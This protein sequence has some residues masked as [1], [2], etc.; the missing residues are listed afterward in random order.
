MAKRLTGL[1]ILFLM[2]SCV[3]ANEPPV[4][5]KAPTWFL[6]EIAT[7]TSDGGRWVADNSEY[8]SEQE[9]YDAYVTEWVASFDGTV[10]SGRLYARKD[11][12]D[13]GNFWEFKQYWHPQRQVA[14]VEQFGWGGTVG[15]GTQWR[16]GVE[17]K[18]SQNF[19]SVDGTVSVT[20]HVSSF[21]TKDSQVTASFDIDGDTWTPRRKYIW[22]RSQ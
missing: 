1:C 17:T 16:E 6:E 11:G 3:H 20:G 10:M 5:A 12:K 18:A 4:P 19:Y 2:A 22:V 7:L 15:I 14:V 13:T 8:K 21:P 9:T